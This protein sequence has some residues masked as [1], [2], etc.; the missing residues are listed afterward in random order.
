MSALIEV[1][2]VILFGIR[3][4]E[5]G[6][7]D[8]DLG[9]GLSGSLVPKK[10]N[11]MSKSKLGNEAKTIN[12]FLSLS[13]EGKRIVLDRIKS[14]STAPRKVTTKKTPASAPAPLPADKEAKCGICG[15]LAGHPDHD[16][17]HY[18]GA[19]KFEPSKSVARAPRKSRQK[20]EIASSV[21]SSEIE[22]VAATS[23]AL[24]VSGG[25]SGD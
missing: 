6:T 15:N 23:A 16:V 4:A 24:A 13:D 10:E 7:G 14:Q 3:G 1:L 18:L 11:Q 17:D 21:Q 5:T 9:G 19:H 2:S 12:L 22:T 20:P 25:S 8:S